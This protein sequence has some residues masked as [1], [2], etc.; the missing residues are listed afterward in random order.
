VVTFGLLALGLFNFITGFGAFLTLPTFI[1]T[2]YDQLGA[3]EYGPTALASAL[4]IVAI[5][6]SGTLWLA[7]AW[8]CLRLL[9]R[10]RMSWW[11]PLVGAAATL[12]ALTVILSVAILADP[13]FTAFT[14]GLE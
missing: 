5:V 4:G 2:A 11:V 6:A 13:T 7:T 9:Q 14:A 12:I 3:G 8:I 10:G 1:Q